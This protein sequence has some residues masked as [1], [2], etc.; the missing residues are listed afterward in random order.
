[1]SIRQIREFVDLS[2]QGASTLRQRCAMLEAHKAH[3][4]EEIASMQKHLRKVSSKIDHFT[5]ECERYAS[6]QDVQAEPVLCR[7]SGTD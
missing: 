1:M 6:M 2:K 5:R 7:L 4:E 3:V